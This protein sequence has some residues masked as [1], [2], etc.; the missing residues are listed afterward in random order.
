[1]TM[2]LAIMQSLIQ[3]SITIYNSKDME[4]TKVCP[5]QYKQQYNR[6]DKEDEVCVFVY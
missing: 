3:S 5:I 2:L 6:V 1:M 4:T